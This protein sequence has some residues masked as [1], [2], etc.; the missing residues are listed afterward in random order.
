MIKYTISMP[1]K[2]VTFLGSDE[3][4]IE[5]DNLIYAEVGNGSGIQCMNSDNEEIIRSKCNQVAN[6]MREIEQL[7]K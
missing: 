7:N 1:F 5:S 2:D 6:L 3:V 4:S